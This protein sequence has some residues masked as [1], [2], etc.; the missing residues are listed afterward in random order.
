M[1]TTTAETW[2]RSSLLLERDA[3][4]RT[5]AVRAFVQDMEQRRLGPQGWTSV[6]S[7]M[8]DGRELARQLREARA[9]P[10]GPGRHAHLRQT[11]DPLPAGR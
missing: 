9:L 3:Q 2:I 8:R 10:E 6:F 11:I 5:G 4:L 7:V 1:T